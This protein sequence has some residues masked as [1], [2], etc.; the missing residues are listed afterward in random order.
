VFNTTSSQADI[1]SCHDGSP[2]RGSTLRRLWSVPRWQ[3]PVT[4][5]GTRGDLSIET[6]SGSISIA[7]H[8]N[9]GVEAVTVAGTISYRGGLPRGD[10]V[11]LASH[12]GDLR[13]SLPEE[14]GAAVTVRTLRGSFE[15]PFLPD[16]KKG[17]KKSFRFTIG[18]GRDTLDL[19]SFSGRIRIDRAD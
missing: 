10:R 7:D 6:L 14:T 12:S 17:K 13:L 18:S 11:S 8:A 1:S 9:G 4:L 2:P 5:L 15:S 19:E 3:G 16:P